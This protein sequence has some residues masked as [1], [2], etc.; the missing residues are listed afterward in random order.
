MVDTSGHAVAVLAGLA[1]GTAGGAA[2][3]GTGA[4]RVLLTTNRLGA[5][6]TGR[7]TGVAQTLPVGGVAGTLA[8]RLRA[9]AKD[10]GT[11]LGAGAVAGESEPRK[12]AS[13]SGATQDTTNATERLTA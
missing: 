2:V 9:R 11:E 13:Q 7:A 6:R 12:Q 10:R 5:T 3:A 4:I 1:A 8:C